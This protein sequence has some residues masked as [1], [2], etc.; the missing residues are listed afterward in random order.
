MGN[1]AI[2]PAVGSFTRTPLHLRPAIEGDI[3]RHEVPRSR[4]RESLAQLLQECGLSSSGTSGSACRR[5][6]PKIK[7]S[8]IDVLVDEFEASVDRSL[9]SNELL[10]RQ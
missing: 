2:Q 9:E 10:P 7:I 1:G 6:A 3:E 4:S 5:H 8:L